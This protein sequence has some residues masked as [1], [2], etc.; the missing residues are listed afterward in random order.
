MKI[1]ILT[2]YGE[3]YGCVLQTLAVIKSFE[4]LGHEAL[5]L[6]DDT[7]NGIKVTHLKQSTLSKL[8]PAY[9]A[10]VLRVRTK[11][12]Y[13]LKNQRD[14]LLLEVLCRKGNLVK[15]KKAK[16]SR[17]AAFKK[18][19]AENI[20]QTDFS[21]SLNN[22]PQDKLADFDFFSVGSD[23]V[24]NP[25]YP[26]TSEVKFLTFAKNHQKLTFAP[27]FGISELP[28]YT[29][30]PYA[31]WLNEFPY[32]S[33][34][35]ERGAEI[36]RNLT[37]KAADVICDPTLVISKEEWEGVE[38]KPKYNTNIP[39]A[40]TYFLGN[41]TNKY[42]RYVERIAKEKNLKIIN[43]FDIREPEFYSTD[44]AEFLYLIHH[45]RA[46]FT[47]S[48]HAAV[49]SIIFKKDFVVFDRIE[50]GQSMGSRIKTLLSKFSLTD[51][52]YTEIRKKSFNSPDFTHSERIIEEERNKALTFLKSSIENSLK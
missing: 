33:V 28:S 12:K 39:Y 14:K 44:P 52:L 11:N 40:L 19:Y 16:A 31:K 23:Q 27:S 9:M 32:L 17:S 6:R 48:F 46:V 45:A 7:R 10:N 8:K 5:L 20:K 36:I 50:D 18:F 13:Y 26:E 38:K 21:I 43:L 2:L 34:R 42:R 24:W 30:E 51:R 49:F 3:N 22:I 1:G 37:G 35:E 4:S 25:T 47:D 41:E 29:R 15:Y